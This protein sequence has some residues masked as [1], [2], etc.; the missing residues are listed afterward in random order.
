MLLHR[1][2]SAVLG[3]SRAVLGELR[4]VERVPASRLALIYNGVATIATGGGRRQ[5][6]RA[7][8]SLAPDTLTLVQVANFIPYKGHRDLIEA[9]AIA[10]P[11][12]PPA[13]RMLLVGRD[14]GIGEQLRN[15]AAAHKLTD[16]ISFLGPRDDVADLLAASD[17]GI[18][19]S[20]QEG[21]SNAVLEGM[22][23]GL[24][25]VVTDVGGNAEAVLDGVT[26][27]VVPPRDPRR[28][29]EAITRLAQDRERR[30]AFG[31]A[32]R[33]RVAE[34]FSQEQCKRRYDMLYRGL[35][36]GRLPAEILPEKA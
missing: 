5:A 21:F 30:L 4:S 35:L 2:M 24:P 31:A 26:G 1:F 25:M 6:V 23:A 3:N 13:W 34:C 14:D 19:A 17:I 8:L 20:H 22:A 36:A 27:L 29:A 33:Q 7:A 15:Q 32:G 9:L 11:A 18:L 10:S 12:L 16:R 28:L